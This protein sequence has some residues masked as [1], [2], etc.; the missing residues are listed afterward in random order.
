M[1]VSATACSTCWIVITI[2]LALT[3]SNPA[4]SYAYGSIAVTF[5]FLFFAAFGSGVLGVPWR[6]FLLN[7]SCIKSQVLLKYES[8]TPESKPI[9]LSFPT[10]N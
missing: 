9:L 5:F 6:K 4:N 3:D 2:V 1:M 10:V 7:S 8:T